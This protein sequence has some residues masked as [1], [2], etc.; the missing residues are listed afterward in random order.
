MISV[1]EET[2]VDE[3]NCTLLKSPFKI[4]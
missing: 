1:D 2:V 3:S 4:Q